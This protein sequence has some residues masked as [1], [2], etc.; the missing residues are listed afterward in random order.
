MSETN[1]K[2]L[3]AVKRHKKKKKKE[4]ASKERKIIKKMVIIKMNCQTGYLFYF[5]CNKM[6][7]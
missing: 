6:C 3:S 2:Y 1:M 4:T 7:C 5:K